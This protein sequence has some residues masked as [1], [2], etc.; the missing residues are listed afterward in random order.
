MA[1]I[2][3][4]L[5]LFP[6]LTAYAVVLD[7]GHAGVPVRRWTRVAWRVALAAVLAATAGYA[8]DTGFASLKRRFG[9]DAYL[10]DERADFEGFYRPE[11]GAAGEFRWMRRRAIVNVRRAQ[12]FRLRFTCIHPD[13]ARDPVVLS[14]RFEGRDVGQIVFRRPEAVERRFD[15]GGPGAL[16]LVVSRTFQPPS[17]RRELGVA[18][19]AIRWE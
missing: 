4:I 1:Y 18:V 10:P 13:A 7:P 14:L 9:L 3:S 17:D 5:L 11:S 6:L 8:S 19:S 12:P 15:L 2:P 16:R